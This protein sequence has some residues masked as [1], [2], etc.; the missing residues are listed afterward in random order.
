MIYDSIKITEVENILSTSNDEILDKVKND[1]KLIMNISNHN[2]WK[3][4]GYLHINGIGKIYIKDNKIT[5]ISDNE[6]SSD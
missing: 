6:E 3:K 4:D 1:K 5:R 2:G